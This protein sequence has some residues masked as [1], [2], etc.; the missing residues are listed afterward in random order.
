M[1]RLS[2]TLPLAAICLLAALTAPATSHAAGG[3]S[4]AA[5]ASG[6]HALRQ[7]AP[8]RDDNRPLNDELRTGLEERVNSVPGTV[9][10]GSAGLEEWPGFLDPVDFGRIIAW[11]SEQLSEGPLRDPEDRITLPEIIRHIQTSSASGQNLGPFGQVSGEK[12]AFFVQKLPFLITGQPDPPPDALPHGYELKRFF[13]F[14]LEVAVSVLELNEAGTIRAAMTSREMADQVL[15]RFFSTTLSDRP[16]TLGTSEFNL[17]MADLFMTADEQRMATYRALEFLHFSA[18]LEEVENV[19]DEIT[20][21]IQGLLRGWIPRT[22]LDWSEKEQEALLPRLR[23]VLDAGDLRNEVGL[24]VRWF[25]GIVGTRALVE[26]WEDSQRAD[27]LLNAVVFYMGGTSQSTKGDIRAVNERL[28]NGSLS[29]P[30]LQEVFRLNPALYGRLLFHI[31]LSSGRFDSSNMQSNIRRILE[32][33][34]GE[35][36]RSALLSAYDAHQAS[37]IPDYSALQ[38]DELERVLASQL[39]DRI[40]R[41]ISAMEGSSLPGVDFWKQRI[42]VAPWQSPE[43]LEKTLRWVEEQDFFLL[44]RVDA[45]WRLFER[46]GIEGPPVNKYLEEWADREGIG[47]LGRIGLPATI[48]A[49]QLLLQ[50]S[51]DTPSTLERMEQILERLGLFA[52]N[53]LSRSEGIPGENP[54]GDILFLA[55]LPEDLTAASSSRTIF[56]DRWRQAKMEFYRDNG[57]EVIPPFVP[58]H[59]TA[60]LEERKLP[61]D[62]SYEAVEITPYSPAGRQ[63]GNR[64]EEFRGRFFRNR[65]TQHLYVLD[66]PSISLLSLWPTKNDPARQ[67]LGFRLARVLRANV[68]D[69]VFPSKSERK[70]F[71]DYLGLPS[72]S[73]IYLERVTTDYKLK[74]EEVLQK[75]S[76][77][78]FT[79]SLVVAIFMRKFDFHDH[80][81]GPLGDSDIPM[82]FDHDEAFQSEYVNMEDFTIAFVRNHF[83]RDSVNAGWINPNRLLER[84]D[85]E[86]LSRSA[87]AV[88]ALDL[89][90]FFEQLNR[91]LPED[92]DL[93]AR[94][95]PLIEYLKLRQRSIRQDL[96]SFFGWLASPD[97]KMRIQYGDKNWTEIGYSRP[98]RLTFRQIR[99]ALARAGLEEA[100]QFVQPGEVQGFE[101]PV[102]NQWGGKDH[103]QFTTLALLNYLK[104]DPSTVVFN[105]AYGDHPLTLPEPWQEPVNV[106]PDPFAPPTNPLRA[107]YLVDTVEGAVDKGHSA[108]VVLLYRPGVMPFWND[109]FF[110]KTWALVQPGGWLFLIQPF[111]LRMINRRLVDFYSAFHQSIQPRSPLEVIAVSPDGS[112]DQALALLLQKPKS[113]TTQIPL[114]PIATPRAGLEE[115][116]SDA[117]VERVIQWAFGQA[118]LVDHWLAIGTIGQWHGSDQFSESLAKWQKPFMAALLSNLSAADDDSLEESQRARVALK[119]LAFR[120]IT[121]EIL[122]LPEISDRQLRARLVPGTAGPGTT[123]ARPVGLEERDRE[124]QRAYQVL[125]APAEDLN[126]RLKRLR[127]ALEGLDG[128]QRLKFFRELLWIMGRREIPEVVGAVLKGQGEDSSLLRERLFEAMR[129]DSERAILPV[130]E[131]ALSRLHPREVATIS[132]V[133]IPAAAVL[134]SADTSE[135]LQDLFELSILRASLHVFEERTESGQQHAVPYL[136]LSHICEVKTRQYSAQALELTGTS[137]P[138]PMALYAAG[139]SMVYSAL[140]SVYAG[141]DF[142]MMNRGERMLFPISEKVSAKID[143]MRANIQGEISTMTGTLFG[144]LDL[145]LA[146]YR[147][148]D[149]L[150]LQ[151]LMFRVELDRACATYFRLNGSED[152]VGYWQDARRTEEQIQQIVLKHERSLGLSVSEAGLEAEPSKLVPGTQ[153]TG[154]AAAPRAGAEEPLFLTEINL[155]TLAGRSELTSFY[156]WPNQMR[157]LEEMILPDLFQRKPSGEV[158]IVNLA[159]A[160]GEETTTT[161]AVVLRARDQF[162]SKGDPT[163]L[164]VRVVG[165]EIDPEIHEKARRRLAGKE[166]LWFLPWG[167]PIDRTRR[168]KAL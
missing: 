154:S 80:N 135:R 140:A 88:E 64:L 50:E 49:V 69:V 124:I 38:L 125:L 98:P 26:A 166:G 129:I 66:T 56:L 168:A 100:V 8:G 23:I 16:P 29:L 25:D 24:V 62:F 19:I 83:P 138:H 28:L 97:G 167:Q 143:A 131:G 61:G 106:D 31:G 103:Q 40:Q 86:E 89:S 60:G 158:L 20:G 148:D 43:N 109:Q 15:H 145:L 54:Y 90:G 70:V 91:D 51:R 57:L 33:S 160:M 53:G 87:E 74:D 144:H 102:F 139:L 36:E 59:R 47:R 146:S 30:F 128:G 93:D 120:G 13:N 112:L 9:R 152:A 82:M 55:Q 111:P 81:L 1:K 32:G 63:F 117:E 2:L 104:L 155:Q 94:I 153:G 22:S 21:R 149:I 4:G 76:R 3:R 108:G 71:S 126:E 96:I 150:S 116:P 95:V 163:S 99:S 41:L 115:P 159:S 127:I 18:G 113:P 105:V 68:P 141:I 6:S 78:A 123:S 107:K 122:G 110:Q 84:I 5:S 136:R 79:C 161:A 137:H 156:R 114:A 85:R 165:V 27:V 52:P 34:S 10:T 72:G 130:L 101:K 77:R 132:L 37:L 11:L 147:G 46:Y 157:L 67:Y 14:F 142:E 17:Q 35:L 133:F 151:L 118:R 92:L 45:Q 58:F 65:Q 73:E 7:E 48:A 12:V 44:E 119:Q 164:K 42:D 39:P 121:P 134:L 75:D 162:V